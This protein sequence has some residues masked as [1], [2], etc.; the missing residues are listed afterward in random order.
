MKNGTDMAIVSGVLTLALLGTLFYSIKTT[1]YAIAEADASD[2]MEA[3][4][5]CVYESG[6]TIYLSSNSESREQ[7][8][9]FG[10]ASE[11]LMPRF[12]EDV[13][14]RGDISQFPTWIIR[15][16]KHEGIMSLQQI[17]Q[18]TGCSL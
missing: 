7:M 4:A 6:A 15:G 18:L 14:E 3:F 11:N 9:M 17:S 16:E 10:N 1:G 8:A 12:C 2:K 5:L 13:C